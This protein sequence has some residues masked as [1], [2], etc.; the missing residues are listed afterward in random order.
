MR[1]ARRARLGIEKASSRCVSVVASGLLDAHF[2]TSQMSRMLHKKRSRDGGSASYDAGFRNHRFDSASRK[3][4]T[5]LDRLLRAQW[6]LPSHL[7]AFVSFASSN[8]SF[9]H[10]SIALVPSRSSLCGDVRRL[11]HPKD[12]VGDTH[13]RDSADPSI[14]N[15]SFRFDPGF[16]GH[17]F[18]FQNGFSRGLLED[19]RE[20]R[21]EADTTDWWTCQRPTAAP[22]RWRGARKGS[23]KAQGVGWEANGG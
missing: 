11:V 22:C 2:R 15:P 10:P 20:T 7:H 17:P 3:W 21:H 1:S 9:P 6:T 5:F 19:A 14:S 23:W 18:P 12:V 4:S 8:S 13:S 16:V